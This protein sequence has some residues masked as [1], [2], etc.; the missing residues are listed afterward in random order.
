[1]DIG[2][3]INILCSRLKPRTPCSIMRGQPPDGRSRVQIRYD[4]KRVSIPPLDRDLTVRIL[5]V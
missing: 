4:L 5:A 1:M 3:P 2:R